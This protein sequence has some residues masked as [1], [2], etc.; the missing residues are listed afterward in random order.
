MVRAGVVARR[1]R[2]SPGS[3]D[4]I[5]TAADRP[6]VRPRGRRPHR[7]RGAAGRLPGDARRPGRAMARRPATRRRHH[8]RGQHEGRDR[9]AGDGPRTALRGRSPDGRPRDDRVR[10][11]PIADLFVDRPWVVV[12]GDDDAAVER[13]ESLARA[14]GARPVRM[15]ATAH[16]QAV[17][18][19]Q[20]PAAGRGR[21]ARRGRR[22]DSMARRTRPTGRMLGAW[23]PAAGATRPGSPAATSRWASGS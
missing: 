20:P 6:D 7:P 21:G 12:P 16:D 17:A 11:P 1:G 14:I 22:R 23:R 9:R 3:R 15:T 10:E 18:G 13:V 19:H 4:G 2:A 8:R 5:A